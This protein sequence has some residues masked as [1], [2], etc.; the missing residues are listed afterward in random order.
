M[1]TRAKKAAGA[2]LACLC[3]RFFVASASEAAITG[4]TMP[5]RA[6][7]K[8][9]YVR[10]DTYAK[11]YAPNV[12]LFLDVG[13][14]ML[15]T[16]FGKLP[17]CRDGRYDAALL[18]QCTY[19]AGA[20]PWVRSWNTTWERYGRDL[21]ATNNE[22]ES[23][24]CYYRPDASKPYKLI[25]RNSSYHV[26]PPA[27]YTTADLVPND[28]RMYKTKL[29]L[30]RVLNNIDLLKNMR[31][32][33]ATSAQEQTSTF[34]GLAADF[35]KKSPFRGGPDWAICNNDYRDSQNVR[36]G[37]LR[38]YYQAR[39]GS[40]NWGRVNRGFLR[41]SF[42]QYS[43]THVNRFL[44]L[45]DG[46]EISSGNMVLNEELIADGQTPLALSIFGVTPRYVRTCPPSC[47][48]QFGGATVDRLTAGQAY[49]SV[50]D[51]FNFRAIQGTCQKNWL[52]VF[53][54]GDDSSGANAVE[55]VKSL[56][57]NSK[58]MRDI[59][60]ETLTMDVPIQ[61]MV[62][63][64]VDPNSTDPDVV[65]LRQTLTG[66]A[67]YGQ[68]LP[69]GS[70]NPNS[71]PYF[72][73]D[74]PGLIGALQSVFTTIGASNYAGG[75]PVVL[76]PATGGTE[77]TIFNSTFTIDENGEWIGTFSKSTLD[78]EANVYR[79]RWEAGQMM[80][81]AA[82][83]NLLTVDWDPQGSAAAEK[84]SGTNCCTVL[85]AEQGNMTPPLKNEI[86][87]S[88]GNQDAN[89]FL[90]WL[91]G[92]FWNGSS[93][94]QRTN[95][96]LDMEHSGLTVVGEPGGVYPDSEYRAFRDAN[97]SRDVVVYIQ[98]NGGILHAFD[99]G[100][101]VE[102]WG[103]I[104]PNV[105]HFNRLA[106]LRFPFDDSRNPSNP[107]AIP[108]MS[109]KTF[110]VYTLDGALV[111][112]DVRLRNG[113]ST[114]LLGALGNAGSGLYAL[115]ISD[116]RKPQFLWALENQMSYG[117]GIVY[118]WKPKSTGQTGAVAADAF[119]YPHSSA[120][121]A[122]DYRRLGMTKGIPVM[123]AVMDDDVRKWVFLD[124][125]GMNQDLA[126]A[127]AAEVGKAIYVSSLDDGSIIREFVS[128]DVRGSLS[129]E[130]QKL[131]MVL[132]PISPI[133]SSA[134]GPI[135]EGYTADHRGHIF[136]IRLDTGASSSWSLSTLFTLKS[137]TSRTTNTRPIVI[138]HTLEVG[139][140][141]GNMWIFGGTADVKGPDLQVL[142]NDAQYI[143]GFNSNASPDVCLIKED[144]YPIGQS[145]DSEFLGDATST[146][147]GK[148]AGWHIRLQSRNQVKKQD[149]EYASTPPVLYGGSLLVSTFIPAIEDPN[150]QCQ[151]GGTARLFIMDADTSKGQWQKSTNMRFVEFSGIK[152]SGLTVSRGKVFLGIKELNPG[153]D[154]TSVEGGILKNSVKR[155]GLLVFDLPEGVGTVEGTL[156][157]KQ[158]VQYWREIFR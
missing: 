123:G 151:V 18:D 29:V 88:C 3:L 128:G 62:V 42:D 115:D 148:T 22:I 28:S 71:K 54:A 90:N 110:P 15:W 24:D 64:F 131:G 75:A 126:S 87:W 7:S 117:Q 49:G 82:S 66:M 52:V 145:N 141:G 78:L 111:A 33:L 150:D 100:T 38:D 146:A 103:F 6:F 137:D 39:E 1:K 47:G 20:R 44:E 9:L 45:I 16:P 32:A 19:G 57:A 143:F 125:A 5:F 30:W 105:L 149:A 23:A 69:D 8:S 144:L 91:R 86:F 121:A 119:L 56:Y 59:Y 81:S 97:A 80:P 74:V 134:G 10:E 14:P 26:T 136:K 25:F 61:T 85:P 13:S 68:P 76:P 35:Y 51:F 17:I 107:T 84:F 89:R 92:L 77:G 102:K 96:L 118:L 70:A 41:I 21:D 135:T 72:A 46:E 99:S 4:E 127:D 158:K 109:S 106:R 63:G 108:S 11:G 153:F 43:T 37:I 139:R 93:Y 122:H 65:A 55:A 40:D 120:P 104:P 31:L 67:Q 101:G 155:G 2:L 138:P 130:T 142:S 132:T 124:G 152:I 34:D 53:T 95:P 113:F 140:F 154:P 36:W 112:E 58:T 79:E 50:K 83:R 133:V 73:N 147:Q 60:G 157:D 12:L 94:V 156:P 129:G 116:P 48:T 98:S 27:S 114:V